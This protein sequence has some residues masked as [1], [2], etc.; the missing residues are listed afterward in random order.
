MSL[1]SFQ[2]LMLPTLSIV[3]QTF[4]ET[5]LSRIEE[6]LARQLNL[7]AEERGGL[8]PSGQQT[9]FANRLNWARCYLVKAGLVEPTRRGYVRATTRGREAIAKGVSEID[10]DFL[11]RYPEF[12][13]WRDRYPAG[14][15]AAECEAPERPEERISASYDE[16]QASLAR[17]LVARV[18]ALSPAFFERLIVEL[19]CRMG[20]GGGKLEMGK[21]LGRSGDGGVDGVIKEDA[22]GLDVVYVQAKRFAQER[23][24]PIREVRDFVGGLEG[25]HASKGVFVTTSYFPSTAYDFVT[26][27]SKRVALIDGAELASLMMRHCVG[28][29]VTE[30]YQLKQLDEG[31]FAR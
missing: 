11:E 16:L 3:S 30:V 19:L 23:C 24:V 28:V 22:L 31:F 15:P 9:L 10:V 25:H 7:S 27:L 5:P 14:G 26:R 13:D 17:E 1:P 6:R 4:E 20:Y 12:R 2:Q 8:A 21:S 29:R 18:A